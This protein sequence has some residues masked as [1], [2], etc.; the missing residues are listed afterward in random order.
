[1]TYIIGWKRKNTVFLSGDTAITRESKLD[2][3]NKKSVFG[4]DL[5]NRTSLSVNEECLKVFRIND[6]VI[7][8]FAGKE[9]PALEVIY[10]LRSYV[11]SNDPMV[12]IDYIF[13]NLNNQKQFS[14][15]LGVMDKDKKARLLSYNLHGDFKYQ[16][17]EEPI[18]DGS[19]SSKYKKRSRDLCSEYA[20]LDISDADVLAIVN[21]VHQSFIV[22]DNLSE[23]SVGGIFWGVFIDSEKIEW[24][25][26][27]TLVLYQFAEGQDESDSNNPS[28]IFGYT[29]LISIAERDNAIRY[30]SPFPSAS[31]SRS[32]IYN[33]ADIPRTLNDFKKKK[34]MV[35]DWHER[36]HEETNEIFNKGESDYYGFIVKATNLTPRVSIFS[37]LG[38]AIQPAKIEVIDNGV[39]D[40]VSTEDF[41]KLIRPTKEAPNIEFTILRCV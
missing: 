24:Q 20:E 23:N 41:I 14:I 6:K 9:S 19:L 11:D 1:M 34:K 30:S 39:F 26:D 12:M 15:F 3:K 29:G 40:L 10:K 13:K 33:C 8:S 38:L 27:T 17:H 36:W 16:E 18:Q 28:D 2:L 22:Q 37:K 25:R 31:F 21:T 5:V 32:V 4:G 7:A 35:I